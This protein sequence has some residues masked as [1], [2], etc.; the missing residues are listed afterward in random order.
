M[1]E[2]GAD[3][4]AVKT[5][6]VALTYVTPFS[7]WLTSIGEKADQYHNLISLSLMAISIALGL[8]WK[9]K[10]HDVKRK[11]DLKAEY[12]R[13]RLEEKIRHTPKD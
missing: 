10:D 9:W 12:N 2:F 11:K 3:D 6:S 8:F 1:L 7:I 13:G 5:V 4:T